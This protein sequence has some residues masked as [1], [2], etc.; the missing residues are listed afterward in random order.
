MFDKDDSATT[1]GYAYRNDKQAGTRLL[2]SANSILRV[3]DFSN[4]IR[5]SDL[6]DLEILASQI[7]ERVS[8][9]LNSR[10]AEGA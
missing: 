6:N 9:I 10:I 2:D 4:K 1:A 5:T 7:K 3:L 8:D